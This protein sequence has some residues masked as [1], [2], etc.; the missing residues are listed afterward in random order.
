MS[1]KKTLRICFTSDLHGYF[2]PTSYATGE[3]GN[4][5]LMKCAGQFAKD[6][7]TLV[8]DGGDIL[9]GSPFAAYCHDCMETPAPMAHIMDLCGYDYVVL[10][11]HDFNFGMDYQRLYVEALGARCLC[12]NLTDENGVPVYPYTVAVLENGLRVGL[13]GIVTDYVNLWEKAEHLEGFQVTEPFEAARKALEE[14]KPQVD[15]TVCVYHGG[16]ERDVA[17]GRLLS[18]TAENIGYRICQELDFDIL[19][20]GHQHMSVPGCDICGTFAVQPAENGREFHEIT[21]TV[22]GRE[23]TISSRLLP[24]DGPCSEEL[25]RALDPVEEKLQRW[26]DSDVGVLEHEMRPGAHIDMAVNGSEIAGLFNLIQLDFTGAQISVTSLANEIAGLPQHV[27]RRDILTTYPYQNT[28]TTLEMTGAVLRA[29][30]ERSAEY[31]ALDEAGDIT[32][33]ETFLKPKVEHYNYDYYAGVEY[34]IDVSKPVGSRVVSLRYEGREVADSDTFTVCASDYRAS[35]AGGYPMFPQCKVLR[36]TDT[37][38]ADVIMKYFENHPRIPTP[39]TSNY[40]IIRG[41][42]A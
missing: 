8:I 20:T 6:G 31:F 4:M 13:V 29:A 38:I 3:E 7:N 2:Y 37:E 35:G 40:R 27:R 1:E 22:D 41:G 23:K 42:E 24:A 36:V 12:Q 21:V 28:L 19:L 25:R 9:Q 30:I 32:V 26:L 16:F 10:G 18:T 33:S 11:N 14:L 15:V 17:T 5:G 34:V 39:D